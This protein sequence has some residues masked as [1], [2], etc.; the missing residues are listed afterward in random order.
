MADWKTPRHLEDHYELHRGELRVRS[1]AE[2]DASAQET[3][4][5]GTRFTFRDPVTGETL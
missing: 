3:I 5:L 2:Y 4:A 1:L